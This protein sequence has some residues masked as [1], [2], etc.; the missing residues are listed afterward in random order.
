MHLLLYFLIVFGCPS[1][2]HNRV[3]FGSN[4]KI[5]IYNIYIFSLSL[6]ISNEDFSII[7]I[8]YIEKCK[9][10]A[11]DDNRAQFSFVDLSCSWLI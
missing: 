6:M 11:A 5:I 9:D 7:I 4:R 3:D 8:N 2:P 10:G 1:I